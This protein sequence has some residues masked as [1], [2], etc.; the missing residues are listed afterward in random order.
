MCRNLKI[1]CFHFSAKN[2]LTLSTFHLFVALFTIFGGSRSLTTFEII[3]T[4]FCQSQKQ[5]LTIKLNSFWLSEPLRLNR[6][7]CVFAY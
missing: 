5:N 7:N 4:F 1:F 6:Q 2:N 3:E